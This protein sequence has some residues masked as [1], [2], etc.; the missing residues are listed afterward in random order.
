[1]RLD[2]SSFDAVPV[3]PLAA[4]L[5]ALV[6][7]L[8]IRTRSRRLRRPPTARQT[9]VAIP[10]PTTSAPV[11]E[12]RAVV[13]ARAPGVGT[14][15]YADLAREH[16]RNG[17]AREAA[18]SQWAA[19]LRVL[20]PLLGASGQQLAGTQ[21][22]AAARD[23]RDAV[24][25]ARDLAVELAADSSG[26]PALLAPVDHVPARADLPVEPDPAPRD[27]TM[28]LDR[29]A[30]RMAAAGRTAAGDIDSART[31]AR[32][33][34]LASFEA[35]LLESAR[36]HGDHR[37]VSLDLRL[38]LARRAL[39]FSDADQQGPTGLD[40]PLDT[41]VARTRAVLRSVVEPHETEALDASFVDAV[42]A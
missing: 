40:E 25:S 7:L 23:T 20:G 22:A 12:A 10:S 29:A 38:D 37:L 14:P 17:H 16:G 41:F 28:L 11:V 5:V 32:E 42:V 39:V 6:V 26:V 15:A 9:T 35:L 27:V 18:V 19:D 8:W 2:T 24:A 36:T 21:A 33:A 31:Q 4:G 3:I 34:D 30:E 13:A 1:M